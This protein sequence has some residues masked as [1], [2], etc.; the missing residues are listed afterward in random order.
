MG[1]GKNKVFEIK[2]KEV[3]SSRRSC[4][5][6]SDGLSDR[7]SDRLT[8]FQTIAQLIAIDDTST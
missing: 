4:D 8:I 3:P 1:R 7:L 5:G 6:L 2:R